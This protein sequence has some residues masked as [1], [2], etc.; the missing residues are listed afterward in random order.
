MSAFEKE[1]RLL[2][3]KDG[4]YVLQVKQIYVEE[5]DEGNKRYRSYWRDLET[6]EE[7]K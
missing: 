6:A 7:D 1:Y 2:H 3:K 4:T 5:D